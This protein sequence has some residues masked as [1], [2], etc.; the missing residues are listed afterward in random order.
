MELN[1]K[2]KTFILFQIVII[3]LIIT[4]FYNQ[5]KRKKEGFEVSSS[6]ITGLKTKLE[7]ISKNIPNLSEK[8]IIDNLV[9]KIETDVETYIKLKR[10]LRL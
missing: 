5:C 1:D 3:I 4:Y 10:F 9:N 6:D 7:I 8:K 2:N